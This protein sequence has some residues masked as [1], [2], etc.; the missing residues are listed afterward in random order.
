MDGNNLGV[1]RHF[2]SSGA[3]RLKNDINTVSP[4]TE[5]ELEALDM[6][7]WLNCRF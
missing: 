5:E 4:Q 7:T 2:S 1:Q 6:K 3:Q